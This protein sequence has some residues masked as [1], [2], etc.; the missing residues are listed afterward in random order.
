MTYEVALKKAWD[1]LLN[2][3]AIGKFAPTNEEDIQCFLYHGLVSELGTAVG[4]GTK[5]TVGKLATGTM[6]F[7]DLA[8]GLDQE[9][10]DVVVEI[11][12]RRNHRK[13]F[14]N[15]CKLDIAKLKQYHDNR[16]H[17]FILFDAN[18]SF[19]FLDQHQRDELS[20][21][22]SANCKIVHYPLGLNTAPQKGWGRKAHQTKT[23]AAQLQA[24][25]AASGKDQESDA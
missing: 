8:L 23:L 22:A 15:R 20:S 11:K 17:Y 2:W 19:V 21:L 13:S 10:P 5:T 9:N 1:H 3:L 18:P 4:I 16:K 12:F 7:P 24:Q 14:Y 25:I 6:H